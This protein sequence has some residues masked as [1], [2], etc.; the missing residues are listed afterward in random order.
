MDAEDSDGPTRLMTGPAP[1]ASASNVPAAR[2]LRP[3]VIPVPLP[4]EA[5]ARSIFDLPQGMKD[6]GTL[7]AAAPA[8]APSAWKRRLAPLGYLAV[9]AAAATGFFALSAGKHGEKTTV[10]VAPAIAAPAVAAP[11][12][13]PAPEAPPPAVVA[14]PAPEPAPAPPAAFDPQAAGDKALAL[15]ATCFTPEQLAS[16]AHF[17]VSVVFARPDGVAKRL[18]FAGEEISA[19]E[20]N[21][22]TQAY[23]GQL[24]A[25]PLDKATVVEYRL[26]VK[27]SGSELKF[28]VPAEK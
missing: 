13:A 2:P 10:G 27:A 12:P 23:V 9:G 16:G 3:S 8:P 22:L 21:C 6:A 17:G 14:A 15:A 20:R 5:K 11:V 24:T 28:H 19:A 1:V 7:P 18:Y 25:G 4:D 26:H